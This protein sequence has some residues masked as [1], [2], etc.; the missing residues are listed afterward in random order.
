ML[1]AQ[2]VDEPR[3]AAG[4]RPSYAATRFVQ[5]VSP[6]KSGT[7]S[8]RSTEPAGG[9]TAGVTSVCHSFVYEYRRRS[10][11]A[12]SLVD[13][14]L[15]REPLGRHR[16]DLGM[17]VRRGVVVRM[18]VRELAELPGERDLLRVADRLVA[19]EHDLP[20]GER[21]RDGGVVLSR[22]RRAQVDAADLRA[23]VPGQ[24]SHRDR[25][26]REAGTVVR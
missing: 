23:G 7:M 1:G 12:A 6:P 19:E 4:D 26:R 10:F 11:L 21:V 24:R 16:V 13:A 2:P 3:A 9:L 17:A 22:Q 18:R 14:V 15:L 8:A 5:V 20:P 25:G